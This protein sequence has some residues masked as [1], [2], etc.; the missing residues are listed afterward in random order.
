MWCNFAN[1]CLCGV[2]RL[3]VQSGTKY[4]LKNKKLLINELS[5]V[6]LTQV[7]SIVLFIYMCKMYCKAVVLFYVGKEMLLGGKKAKLF[8]KLFSLKINYSSVARDLV[9][10]ASQP[11][12]AGTGSLVQSLKNVEDE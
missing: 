5:K 2:L 7:P 6:R 12:T 10:I 8:Q 9:R 3:K 11:M 4:V 1:R